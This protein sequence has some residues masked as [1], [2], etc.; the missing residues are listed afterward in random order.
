[1]K[2]IVIFSILCLAMSISLFSADIDDLYNTVTLLSRQNRDFKQ[3]QTDVKNYRSG[4]YI[5]KKAEMLEEIAQNFN[6]IASSVKCDPALVRVGNKLINKLNRKSK[7][8]K[9]KKRFYQETILESSERNSVR[10]TK[11]PSF[12]VKV[13]ETISELKDKMYDE[14]MDYDFSLGLKLFKFKILEG[15]KIS[16]LY[17]YK[18]DSDYRKGIHTRVDQW[19]LKIP[20]ELGTVLKNTIGKSVP[21][22]LNITPQ[23]K[24]IFARHFKTKKEAFKALPMTPISIP[25]SYE[26]A[27]KLKTGDFVSIPTSMGFSAGLTFGLTQGIFN[28]GASGGVLVTG[29]FR[30]NVY[31]VD[32]HHI[33][34]KITG[35]RSRGVN[36]QINVSYGLK[37][38]G[39]DPTGL[40][41]LDDQAVN[42]LGSNLFSISASKIKAKQLT[43]DYTFDL[44]S[45]QACDAYDAIVKNAFRFKAIEIGASFFKKNGL[46]KIIFG[47][48]N[49]AENLYQADKD[50]PAVKRRVN[51]NFMGSIYSETSQRNIKIGMRLLGKKSS[52]TKVENRIQKINGDDSI[53]HYI[54]PIFTKKSEFSLFFGYWKEKNTNIALSFQQSNPEWVAEK[55]YNMI[56]IH[57][58]YD[59]RC[60]ES[61]LKKFLKNTKNTL[62]SDMI[63]K[64]GL[65]QYND[66]KFTKSFRAKTKIVLG[67]S[68][69][70][71][72]IA[73]VADEEKIYRAIQPVLK[74]YEFY[75]PDFVDADENDTDIR[76]LRNWSGSKKEAAE[77]CNRRWGGEYYWNQLLVL[78][79][80]IKTCKGMNLFEAEKTI[81]DLYTDKKFYRQILP[82]LLIELIRQNGDVSQLYVSVYFGGKNIKTFKN[83]YGNNP[84]EGIL[85]DINE[86]I[87]QIKYNS[88]AIPE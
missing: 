74:A 7:Y 73:S 61:E 66:V 19:T 3:V 52:N 15:L 1:M 48:L 42:L 53:D 64:I 35:M 16:A 18:L 62:G 65:D 47:D 27:L 43:V 45:P 56:F 39:H 55:F 49:C 6:D 60:R 5:M 77:L 41:D 26:K 69:I 81:R 84:F 76:I 50:L 75:S 33:R 68:N 12:F 78:V 17:K 9:R 37:F 63:N 24:I 79:K 54:Y 40:I 67:N 44:R 72:I 14:F 82:R 25:L 88:D 70:K 32:E 38:F 80:K 10:K 11:I 13:K 8:N 4:N 58:A 31:K 34:M 86:L 85:H 21:V 59:K 36:G 71:T 87:Y 46:N 28:A 30:V 83:K 22:Y 20:I 29:N 57:N 2:V 23:K 51:R